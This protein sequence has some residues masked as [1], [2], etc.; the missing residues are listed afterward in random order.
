MD[1]TPTTKEML[2]TSPGNRRLRGWYV[3]LLAAAMKRGGGESYKPGIGFDLLGR[4]RDAHH[5]LN[6]CIQAGIPFT[7]V[8]VFRNALTPTK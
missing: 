7:S 5:R 8:V 2:E 3:D 6:A 1:I 4:L